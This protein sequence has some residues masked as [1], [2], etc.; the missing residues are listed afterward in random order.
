MCTVIFLNEKQGFDRAR[1]Q[2][3]KAKVHKIFLKK[4]FFLL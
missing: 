1:T 4:F 2:Y 3:K